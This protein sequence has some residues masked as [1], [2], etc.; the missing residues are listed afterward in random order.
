M[1]CRLWGCTELGMTE[2]T[3]QQQQQQQEVIMLTVDAWYVEV[4]VYFSEDF[5]SGRGKV[6]ISLS[7]L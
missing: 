2:A 4:K 1:G 6:I 3:S 5:F 7:A